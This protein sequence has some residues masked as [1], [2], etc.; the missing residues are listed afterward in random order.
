MDEIK[1]PIVLVVDDDEQ[2]R[3]LYTMKLAKAG[4]R[5]AKAINGVEAIQ[6]AKNLL[7]DLIL[8]DYEMPVMNGVEALEK[9]KADPE[10][11]KLRVVFLTAFGDPSAEHRMTTDKKFAQ[12]VGALDYLRKGID[13]DELVQKVKGYISN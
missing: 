2:L 10:T 5:V 8:M 7:P 11:A 12:D 1:S 13:L 4:Y 9:L 3:E 6:S